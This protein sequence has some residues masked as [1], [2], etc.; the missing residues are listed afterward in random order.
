LAAGTH[1]RLTLL[2]FELTI[3][4]EIGQLPAFDHCVACNQPVAPESSYAL[5]LSQGGIICR[6]CQR[7]DLNQNRIPAGTVAV[8]RRLSQPDT[9]L[10]RLSVSDLQQ[11]QMRQVVN[12]AVTH[13]LG[14]RPK[15]I[16]YLTH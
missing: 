10:S 4:R 1:P 12:S 15:M 13:I 16:R 9:D 3:L 8:L 11:K 14:R 7:E 6:D 5:W 2:R